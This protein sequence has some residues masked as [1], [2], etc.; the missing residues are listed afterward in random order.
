MNI[1]QKALT[2]LGIIPKP[3]VE[4]TDTKAR[5]PEGPLVQIKSTK[6]LVELIDGEVLPTKPSG[7]HKG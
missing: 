7:E 1:I 5:R 3:L 2:K 4:I 6:P